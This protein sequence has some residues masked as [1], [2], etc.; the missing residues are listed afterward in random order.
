MG[1]VRLQASMGT[2][3]TSHDYTRQGA[4]GAAEWAGQPGWVLG[5]RT[6]LEGRGGADVVEEDLGEP[7]EC[8]LRE[9]EGGRERPLREVEEGCNSSEGERGGW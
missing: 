2:L 4:R 5:R 1:E 3:I 8:G 7:A 6:H 9:G